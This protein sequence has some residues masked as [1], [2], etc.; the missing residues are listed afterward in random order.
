MECKFHWAE[1]ENPVG[2]DYPEWER[3]AVIDDNG[4]VFVPAVFSGQPE[5][6]IRLT[7]GF[8]GV[9]VLPRSSRPRHELNLPASR[10]SPALNGWRTWRSN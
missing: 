3:S 8:D 9:S 4:V 1:V 7:C 6:I 5:Y 10:C 2:E